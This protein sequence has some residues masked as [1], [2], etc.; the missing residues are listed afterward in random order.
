VRHFRFAPWLAL[1]LVVLFALWSQPAQAQTASPGAALSQWIGYIENLVPRA[2]T[3]FEPG[4]SEKLKPAISSAELWAVNVA[5]LKNVSSAGQGRE[6]IKTL[7]DAKQRVDRLLDSTLEIRGQF[8][9]IPEQ[10]QQ[11]EAARSYLRV[12]AQLIDFSGRL[13]YLQSDVLNGGIALFTASPQDVETLLDL[14]IEYRSS[15]GASALIG[16]LAEPTSAK[17]LLRRRS[18]S[19]I[20]P[21][22]LK[23]ISVS[24]QSSLLPQVAE[25]LSRS[26]LP[27]ALVIEAAETIR[28]VGLP[29][30]PR[31][32]TP[33]DLPSPAITARQLQPILV[34]LPAASLSG[35]LAARRSA[36]LGWL[37]GQVKS[38]LTEES[39]RLGTFEVQP[40]DWLLMRNPSP[41]N[42]FTNL[43]PGLFTHVGVVTTE[44][45]ADGIKRMVLVD[46]EERGDH[47]PATNVEIFVQRSLH[48]VFL[49]HPDRAIAQGM[50]DAA[51]SVIGNPT[52]FDLNFRTDRVLELQG[53][54]LAGRKIKTYCAGLLLLCALQTPAN[55]AELFPLAEGPS[56][57]N[58]V[59]NLAKLGMSFGRD[60]S[61][62]T[63]A[64]FSPRLLL[65]GRREPMYD[66][67]REVEEAVFDH[68]AEGLIHKTLIPS[69]DLYD[70]LRLKLAEAT[71]LSP[72]LAQAMAK[73]VGVSA[74][75]DLVS[76]AKTA[77]VVE[78]LDEIA[79][80]ASADFLEARDA[81]RGGSLD[82]LRKEGADQETLD[83][84]EEYRRRH[85]DF[86][87]AVQSGQWSARQVRVA[88]VQYY[89]EA[90]KRTIDERFFGSKP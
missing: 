32:N 5:N 12:T 60:F 35:D 57:G 65:V 21:K 81:M 43:A 25:F 24:G 31:P 58:T 67:R 79:F 37:D 46:L 55:R 1:A 66:P 68:F 28:Q 82:Q 54:P 76:A 16:Q 74:D 23:L 19:D 90:G 26:D 51:R 53:K 42:L 44:T 72:L 77:A 34:R 9:A 88:L 61:S 15:I 14:L 41:Y 20:Q 59:E 40:G 47:M 22:L 52:E 83:L 45:G 8:A 27:P 56:G 7:L 85:A 48:Y 84:T 75:M 50:S 86:Y 70:S 6:V 11:H 29:Q 36:L 10:T 89:S 49:R 71:K 13:R 62:P 17:G 2:A 4:T 87:K 63:G 64:L 3:G 33:K 78:T 18:G 73:A 80:D 69:P 38:G 30:E 39:Y